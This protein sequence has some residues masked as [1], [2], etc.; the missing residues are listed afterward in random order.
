MWLVT[1]LTVSFVVFLFVWFLC[2][3]TKKKAAPVPPPKPIP[4][5]SKD[6]NYVAPVKTGILFVLFQL[7]GIGF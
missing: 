6:P 5:T 7:L 3:I 4:K 2:A 1:L